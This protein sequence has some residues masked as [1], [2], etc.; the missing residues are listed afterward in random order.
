MLMWF[1]RPLLGADGMPRELHYV[2][3]PL[4]MVQACLTLGQP[5]SPYSTCRVR[6]REATC[7]GPK[8]EL[9]FQESLFP[10]DAHS[11]I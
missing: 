6:L 9:M 8:P 2:R 3:P 4:I 11:S 7:R 1:G 10:V 5:R